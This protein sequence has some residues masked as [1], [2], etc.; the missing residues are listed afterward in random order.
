MPTTKH[1]IQTYLDDDL[2]RSLDSYAQT[3]KL[4]LS[5]SVERILRSFF[6]GVKPEG[7][8][9]EKI[10]R[11][12]DLLSSMV[13]DSPTHQSESELPTH[14]PESELP[15]HQSESELPTHQPESEL[16]THQLESELP[17]HPEPTGIEAGIIAFREREGILPDPEI[18]MPSVR[19]QNWHCFVTVI[20]PR[21][22]Q[23]REDKKP[24]RF[25]DGSKWNYDP[26]KLRIYAKRP[27]KNIMEK[28]ESYAENNEKVHFIEVWQLLKVMDYPNLFTFFHING[29]G[30]V[31][32]QSLERLWIEKVEKMIGT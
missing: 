30:H 16:P 21:F 14:Q 6:D 28:I 20:L 10:R 17:T 1:R 25:W 9:R 23:D 8:E 3:Q 13:G 11:A 22:P 12:I 15:T 19:L 7:L 24:W 27:A 5:Q 2:L 32:T 29:D 18:T 4:S 26:K 31:G